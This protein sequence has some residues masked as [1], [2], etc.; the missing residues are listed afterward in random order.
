[1]IENELLSEL[2]IDSFDNYTIIYNYVYKHTIYFYENDIL[3][4]EDSERNYYELNSKNKKITIDSNNLEIDAKCIKNILRCKKKCEDYL[5]NIKKWLDNKV[6]YEIKLS[7]NFINRKITNSIDFT[8]EYYELNACCFDKVKRVSQELNILFKEIDYANIFN[9][10][11]KMAKRILIPIDNVIGLIDTK[12]IIFESS[13]VAQ[14]LSKS[15]N[16][17]NEKRELITNKIILKSLPNNKKLPKYAPFNKDSKILYDFDLLKEK[18]KISENCIFDYKNKLDEL[19]QILDSGYII[20]KLYF[21][22][23]AIDENKNVIKALCCGVYIKNNKLINVFS[24][25]LITINI[26]NLLNNIKYVSTNKFFSNKI[27]CPD[28]FADFT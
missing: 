20:T 4:V 22:A 18:N 23:G 7:Y 17:I 14:L 1:M 27:L 10:L 16:L 19:E 25:K 3:K 15:L 13:A 28:I 5:N 8:N 11:N 24:N 26:F 2:N 12:K 6:I 21:S 9:M